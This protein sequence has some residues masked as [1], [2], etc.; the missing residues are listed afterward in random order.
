[1]C[2]TGI[3]KILL[4]NFVYTHLRMI[5]LSILFHLMKNG[6]DNFCYI[7]VDTIKKYT[8]RKNIQ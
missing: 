4:H 7:C 6:F 2:F 8:P 1:M 3:I 5:N